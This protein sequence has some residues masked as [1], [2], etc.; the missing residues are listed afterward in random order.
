MLWKL[1]H[2]VQQKILK[3]I[4]CGIAP[5]HLHFANTTLG[6]TIKYLL[7]KIQAIQNRKIKIINKTG[8]NI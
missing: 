6:N 1:K 2:Y 4:Y 3:I 5:P 8:T 7:K